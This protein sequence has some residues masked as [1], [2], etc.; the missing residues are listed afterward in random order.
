MPIGDGKTGMYPLIVP[1]QLSDSFPVC[2]GRSAKVF[3][4]TSDVRGTTR[5]SAAET[6][7]NSEVAL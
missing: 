5:T 1:W 2:D 3:H 4:L 6:Q 7:S